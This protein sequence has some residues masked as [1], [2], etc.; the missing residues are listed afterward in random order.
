M[1]NHNGNN[2]G[3]I[4]RKKHT[5]AFLRRLRRSI[6]LSTSSMSSEQDRFRSAAATVSVQ[7][8]K[9]KQVASKDNNNKDDFHHHQQQ[10]QGERIVRIM[11]L[12]LHE[13]AAGSPATTMVQTLPLTLGRR[14]LATWWWDACWDCHNNNNNNNINNNNN[15]NI[16]NRR[17]SSL[18]AAASANKKRRHFCAHRCRP[19]AKEVECLSKA[20]MTISKEGHLE[21]TGKNTGT[22]LHILQDKNKHNEKQQQQRLFEL[23]VG[24]EGEQ[25][26]MKFRIEIPLLGPHDLPKPRWLTAHSKGHKSVTPSPVTKPNAD[27][28]AMGNTKRK[29]VMQERPGSP[30]SVF[31]PE[32]CFPATEAARKLRRNKSPSPPRKR[33]K[34]LAFPS[35]QESQQQQKK[36]KQQSDDFIQRGDDK[37]LGKSPSTPR[38]PD[39]SPTKKKKMK[40]PSP[41]DSNSDDLDDAEQIQRRRKQKTAEFAIHCNENGSAASTF[42]STKKEASLQSPPKRKLFNDNANDDGNDDDSDVGNTDIHHD[43]EIVAAKHIGMTQGFSALSNHSNMSEMDIH[44]GGDDDNVAF[45]NE[46]DHCHGEGQVDV[47]DA[48]IGGN[49]NR[50]SG[51]GAM[52]QGINTQICNN[53]LD[54]DKKWQKVQNNTEHLQSARLGVDTPEVQKKAQ[55][56]NAEFATSNSHH[57]NT[58]QGTQMDNK[59]PKQQMRLYCQQDSQTSTSSSSTTGESSA[60]APVESQQAT[61]LFSENSASGSELQPDSQPRFRLP[62]I[63]FQRLNLSSE[64][65]GHGGHASAA[66]NTCVSQLQSQQQQLQSQGGSAAEEIETADNDSSSGLV[67]AS[68][69]QFPQCRRAPFSVG[70]GSGD[71]GIKSQPLGKTQVDRE[72]SQQAPSQ[73]E[74]EEVIGIQSATNSQDSSVLDLPMCD[75]RFSTQSSLVV[76]DN[77]NHPGGSGCTQHQQ[78]EVTLS[79]EKPRIQQL[80]HWKTLQQQKNGR[81]KASRAL[82]DLIVEKN[83]VDHNSNA[84]GAFWLPSILDDC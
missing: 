50:E 49:C 66:R 71:D 56:V 47:F 80:A 29:N 63:S 67:V 11:A 27:N 33:P 75:I 28:A 65:G 20:M 12:P 6:Q 17:K 53:T 74:K 77:M 60:V 82:I 57:Q 70:D 37:S 38:H 52:T 51:T 79:T 9:N 54:R 35:L 16:D 34:V 42:D 4:N 32:W 19:L 61:S 8:R 40:R 69:A 48:D 64:G 5:S 1:P 15:N 36:K 44:G 76:H 25:P 13:D 45:D 73:E 78:D 46:G 2:A 62:P 10:Q 83:Q 7:K 31:S 59:S 23:S 72:M 58:Q 41:F 39:H 68:Q 22:L 43:K 14:N 18:S 81:S 55:H 3:H 84:S 24:N 26:W 21:F 30:L